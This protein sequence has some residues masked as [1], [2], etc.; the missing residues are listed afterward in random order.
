MQPD[1]YIQER[2]EEYV[3][4]KLDRDQIEGLWVD[5]LKEP[6]W[7]GYL[8]ITLGLRLLLLTGSKK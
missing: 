6:E 3:A 5:L 8:K 4:G 7:V 1:H 2:I